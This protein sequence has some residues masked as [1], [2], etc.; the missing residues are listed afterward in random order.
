MLILFLESGW[1]FLGYFNYFF[2][3]IIVMCLDLGSLEKGFREDRLEEFIVG[4]EVEIGCEINIKLNGIS[5][6]KCFLSGEWIGE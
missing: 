4:I 2:L 6:W 5:K 1:G 3:V